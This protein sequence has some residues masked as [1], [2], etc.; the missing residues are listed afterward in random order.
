MMVPTLQH[1]DGTV[2]EEKCIY[3]KGTDACLQIH[4][5]NMYR[6]EW[7]IYVVIFFSF[8]FLRRY[9]W[10][11]RLGIEIQNVAR[12]RKQGQSTSH[13]SAGQKAGLQVNPN[14]CPLTQNIIHLG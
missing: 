5:I 13:Q 6:H 3:A 14:K 12:K 8:T 1:K 11:R 7:K 4:C 2:V 9:V 10:L